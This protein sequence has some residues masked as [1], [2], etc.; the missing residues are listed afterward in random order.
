MTADDRGEV[1]AWNVARGDV[2]ERFH[3]H[4][5]EINAIAVSGDGRTLYTVAT[6][7]RLAIWD[8]AGDRRLDRRFDAGPPLVNPDDQYPK[9]MALSPDG[10][11]LA[12]AQIDGTVQF[13]DTR[14]FERRRRLQA[15][16]GAATAVDFSPDGRRLAVLSERGQVTLWDAR[17]LRP[18]GE[19]RGLQGFSQA[20]AFS[21]DGS[22]LAGADLNPDVNSGVLV[23][24]IR[25][26]EL[27]APRFRATAASLAFSP[28]G[29]LLA[30]SGQ[31]GPT[32][33][34]DARS[35]K[36]VASLE[37]E[38]FARSV[39][40]SPDGSLLAVGHYGGSARLWSTRTWKPIGRRMDGH[41]ARLTAVRFS[42]DGRT[43]ASASADGTVLLWDVGTQRTIGAPLT[44]EPDTYLAAAFT[45]HG[46]QLLVVPHQGRGVRWDVRPEAWKRHACLVA[47]REFTAREWRDTLPDHPYRSVCRTH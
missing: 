5:S 3:A 36:L 37:T 47:G 12:V 33:V 32:Q 8:L 1:I 6:D 41:R 18:A 24:N 26:R 17:T 43:L 15:V 25:R 29:R 14:T 7:A 28:D 9:G 27:I 23:W 13:V 2:R 22:L 19:L 46:A 21:P 42:P 40:F 38:D 34:R 44:I 39:A 31:E 35:G 20:I 10:R 11:T 16:R 45:P 30:A 4:P